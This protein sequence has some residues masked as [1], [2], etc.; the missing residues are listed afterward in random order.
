MATKKSSKKSATTPKLT[1]AQ[2][3][4][5]ICEA[6][7]EAYQACW[8]IETHVGLLVAAADGSELPYGVVGETISWHSPEVCNKQLERLQDSLQEMQTLAGI[9]EPLFNVET[10]AAQPVAGGAA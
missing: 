2:R 7:K 6:L 4:Q 10:A 8:I 3:Q 1:A 9:D 5:K